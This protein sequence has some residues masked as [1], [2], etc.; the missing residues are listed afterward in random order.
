MASFLSSVS[1]TAIAASIA[2][3]AMPG[4]TTVFATPGTFSYTPPAGVRE[5]YVIAV[6]GGG[7]GGGAPRNPWAFAKSGGGA[8]A[9]GA[10]SDCTVRGNQLGATETVIVG[11]GG[12]GG[13][14]RTT[15][16]ASGIAGTSGGDSSFGSFV[17]ALGG[18]FGPAGVASIIAGKA[19]ST[20]AVNPGTASPT[21]VTVDVTAMPLRGA[22]LAPGCGSSGGS[23][24]VLNVPLVNVNG[25]QAGTGTLGGSY[26]VWP[27]GAS[28]NR[29]V[30]D[31]AGGGGGAGG[32]A[33]IMSTAGSPELVTNGGFNADLSNWIVVN[34]GASAVTW[35]ASGKAQIVGDGTNTAYLQQ[36]LATT[37]GQM[38]LLTY[39]ANGTSLLVTAYT[40]LNRTGTALATT[41]TATPTAGG[42]SFTATTATT[43]I[44]FGRAS[45]TTPLLIDNV[46][47]KAVTS[48]TPGQTGGK[49][50]FPGGGGGGGGAA[51]N[52]VNSG[53]GGAGGDGTVIIFESY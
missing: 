43:Y 34:A 45:S 31:I 52:D 24:S 4:T 30:G 19:G 28:P 40:G 39:D 21:S 47:V 1:Y 17:L 49:G 53:A 25:G 2:T 29:A 12:V 14:A 15:N 9:A 8:G 5:I 10:W 48:T 37:P 13:A 6:G 36:A 41:G 11:A 7:G 50:G 23:I 27:G 46:S 22:G 32:A 3:K 38:Y 16:T 20:G 18:G 26:G 51:M 33:A 42:L 44:T 35:D